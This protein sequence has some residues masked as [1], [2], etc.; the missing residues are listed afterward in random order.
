[1]GRDVRANGEQ[2]EDAEAIVLAATRALEQAPPP[3]RRRPPAPAASTGPELPLACAGAG[4]LT[5]MK[6]AAISKSC[7][8][9]RECM[10]QKMAAAAAEVLDRAARATGAG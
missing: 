10:R 8:D 2:H 6:L 5:A 3:P 4:C 9:D 7:A 1:M